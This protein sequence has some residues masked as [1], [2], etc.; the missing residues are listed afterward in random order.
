MKK[1]LLAAV[2][3]LAML[4][5]AVSSA[6][7]LATAQVNAILDLLRAFG[8]EQSVL[9]GV[10]AA[11][12]APLMDPAPATTTTPTPISAAH[13]PVIGTP[14][15]SS[16]LGYDI[17]F[18][19]RNY[20]Q[21]PFGF[22]VIG[23]TAGKSFTHNPRLASEFSWARFASASAPGIY[24]NLNAPYGSSA[25]TPTMSTPRNCGQLFG[26]ATTSAAA[27]GTFPEPTVCG[28]YNYGYNAAKDA[29]AYASSQQY[30]SS[31]LWWLDIEEAN[32]WSAN[33]AVND[34]VIQGAID[35]LNTKNIRV[36]LYSVPYMWNNIAGKGFTPTESIGSEGETVPTWFPIGISDQ[37][38]AINACLTKPS[39]IPNSPVWVI[40]YESDSTA[41]DQNI[42]C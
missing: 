19:T 4:L 10:A 25:A 26:A 2:L 33:T 18:A 15:K 20:P 17:S 1:T 24:V 40:Q 35:F 11:L 6:A 41:V 3:S 16:S 7:G 38:G 27:G 42:A 12:G 13:V 8:A 37:V 31:S 36:G 39:F 23:V 9:A 34:A 22:A 14:Y 28:S 29:Y 21:I 32:S 5:P 30:V